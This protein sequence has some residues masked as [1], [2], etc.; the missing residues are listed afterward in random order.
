MPTQGF[1]V[2]LPQRLFDA[3]N[4]PGD[5][6]KVFTW[7]ADGTFTTP[8]TTWSDAGLTSANTNPIICDAAGYFVAFVA[9]GTLL[10]ISVQNASGVDQFTLLSQEPMVDTS[11]GGG[12]VTAVPTG[13]I[14]A[15]GAAA[16]PTGFL[17][18]NGSLVNRATYATLFGVIGTTYGAGDGSTTF[19]LPDGRGRFLM[20][21]AA[22][23]TGNTLGATFGAIDHTHTGPSHT[24]AASVLR[25]GWGSALNT[26]ST[27]GRLNVGDAAGAGAFASSYQPS[28]DLAITTAAGGTGNT[29]TGNPPGLTVNFIIKT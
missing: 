9:A 22:S 10:D 6:W 14:L 23:G 25:D 20:G 28:A 16:A 11:G 4:L 2:G 13:G 19:G 24:H 18:C 12:S 21:V 8:L 17:L 27:T 5:A 26:P 29:G 7:V 3:N 15:F 1:L